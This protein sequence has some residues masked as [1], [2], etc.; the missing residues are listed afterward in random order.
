MGER[1]W[2]R[3]KWPEVQF[4]AVVTIS[5]PLHR[6]VTR[7]CGAQGSDIMMSGDNVASL[8]GAPLRWR[9]LWQLHTPV[10][11]SVEGS[12]QGGASTGEGTGAQNCQCLLLGENCKQH[13]AGPSRS[14]LEEELLVALL[15]Q[16]CRAQMSRT[17][18]GGIGRLKHMGGELHTASPCLRTL[19][20]DLKKALPVSVKIRSAFQRP[21]TI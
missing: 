12:L 5:F 13:K 17:A 8:P 2:A 14:S 10:P 20:A 16:R 11:F 3:A 9:R 15:P 18:P 1:L 7:S 6:S 19:P 4:S 21:S